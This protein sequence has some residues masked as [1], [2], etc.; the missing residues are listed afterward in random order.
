FMDAAAACLDSSAWRRSSD[1]T[2]MVDFCRGVQIPVIFTE[3]VAAPEVPSLREDPFG[4]EHMVP[5]RGGPTGWGLRAGK[6]IVGTHGPESP[7]TIDELK[8]L[9][10][11]LVVRG[12]SVDKFYGT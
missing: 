2:K 6:C 4:P 12:F 10:G 5:A 1:M 11:E 3:F 8:P 9:P 7:D